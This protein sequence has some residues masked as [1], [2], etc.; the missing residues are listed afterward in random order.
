MIKLSLPSAW[1][2]RQ[3]L[4]L[5]VSES[6]FSGMYNRDSEIAPIAQA[7]PRRP[8]NIASLED[9]Y[10]RGAVC[11]GQNHDGKLKPLDCDFS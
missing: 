2:R 9:V 10:A 5:G 11:I 8:S 6:V 4:L 3:A 1:R 7:G